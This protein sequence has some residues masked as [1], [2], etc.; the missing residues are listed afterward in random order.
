MSVDAG[1]VDGRAALAV[2]SA[3]ILLVHV[4]PN[5]IAYVIVGMTT[6][7]GLAI[8][9]EASISISGYGVPPGT[10]SW[11]ADLSGPSRQFFLERP[12]ALAPGGAISL[13]LLGFNLLGDAIRDELDPRLRGT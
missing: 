9:L 2:D 5:V 1:Y 4:L 13:T 6:S 8:L 12:A 10:A 7:L 3:R 11:G